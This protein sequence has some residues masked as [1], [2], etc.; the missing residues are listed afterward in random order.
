M[1]SVYKECNNS[2]TTL[3]DCSKQVET[4]LGE[5]KGK[6]MAV[7][8][9]VITDLRFLFEHNVIKD[10]DIINDKQIPGTFHYEVADLN[11]LKMVVNQK[12]GRKMNK[13]MLDGYDHEGIHD[14]LV[15]CFN[16]TIELNYMLNVIFNN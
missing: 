2:N 13:R 4:F 11:L 3:Q 10:N 5:W 12:M 6:V 8:D 14:A 15:D 9:C 16:Q 7:G 1:S